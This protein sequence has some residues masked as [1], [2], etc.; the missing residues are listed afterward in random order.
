M[1]LYT[2]DLETGI[3]TGEIEQK[4]DQPTT[5]YTGVI[6]YFEYP[7]ATLNCPPE[8]HENECAMMV[9]GE[10]TIIPDFRGMAFHTTEDHTTRYISMIGEWPEGLNR[11]EYF[12]S[13]EELFKEQQDEKIILIKENFDT[14]VSKGVKVTID[15]VIYH[16]DCDIKDCLSLKQGIEISE[17]YND[18]AIQLTDYNN[19]VTE[20]SIDNAKTINQEQYKYFMALRNNKC[21]LVSQTIQEEL[22]ELV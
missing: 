6:T 17:S 13:K 8:V 16:M 2:F 18:T 7:Y 19:I 5:D 22:Q 4:I 9:D 20:V 11:G 3:H 15:G 1:K 21:L 12:K 14:E 10:W